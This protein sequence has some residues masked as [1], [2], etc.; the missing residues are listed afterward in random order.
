[1]SY[2]DIFLPLTALRLYLSAQSRPLCE[3]HLAN[4]KLTEERFP[5]WKDA[6]DFLAIW[7]QLPGNNVTLPS[8]NREES[9]ISVTVRGNRPA[10]TYYVSLFS[11]TYKTQLQFH[12]WGERHVSQQAAAAL[13]SPV[14]LFTRQRGNKRW[15]AQWPRQSALS[16]LRMETK[17]SSVRRN[18]QH[19]ISVFWIDWCQWKMVPLLWI[20]A[21]ILINSFWMELFLLPLSLMKFAVVSFFPV[22]ISNTVFCL[23]RAVWLWLWIC[24]LLNYANNWCSFLMFRSHL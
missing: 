21:R 19:F 23:K 14:S 11:P 24:C 2:A 5:F 12:A 18:A 16:S 6:A 3:L 13:P 15:N 8:R 17:D 7:Q 4:N 10:S 9:L 20:H 1:M 22:F